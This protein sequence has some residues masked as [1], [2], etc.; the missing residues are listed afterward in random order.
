MRK[1]A[2]SFVPG[3]N[4]EPENKVGQE[5]QQQTGSDDFLEVKLV[6]MQKKHSSNVRSSATDDNL[7]TKFGKG[8][9][10]TTRKSKNSLDFKMPMAKSVSV[11][12]MSR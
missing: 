3:S 4:D 11:Q 10:F 9:R 1:K 7:E 5:Q 12:P 8:R 2:T 6:T